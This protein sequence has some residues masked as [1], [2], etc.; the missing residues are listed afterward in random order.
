MPKIKDGEISDLEI[1]K[2]IVALTRTKKKCYLIYNEW[3]IK[4][5]GPGTK[6]GRS[7]FKKLLP[8]KYL[9][10]IGKVNAKIIAKWNDQK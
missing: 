5:D 2:F 3:F 8:D 7:S 4:Q 9:N 10:N 1:C 6:F